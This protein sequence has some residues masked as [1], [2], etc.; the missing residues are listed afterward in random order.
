MLI[1]HAAELLSKSEYAIVLTGAGISTP[2]GIPDFRSSRGGLWSKYDPMLVASLS[3][4]RIW[5][6]KFYQF[7]RPLTRAIFDALPNAAHLALA[8]LEKQGIVKEIIT[9]NVDGLHQKAGS[10]IVHEVHGTVYSLTCVNCYTKYEASSVIEA[11]IEKG[12]IPH[13][14]KCGSILKPDTVLSEEQLPI[15]VWK[16]ADK[17]VKKCDLMLVAGS[18]LEA[19]PVAR[20]PY[21]AINRGAKLI[22]INNEKTYIDPRA[23]VVI[24]KD[25][26]E[27]LPAIVE[28]IKK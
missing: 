22:I 15:R 25:V 10:A 21:D 6:E 3:A 17:A 27:A 11:F 19:F 24:N 18:S 28:K 4:F 13:C 23:D 1:E 20:L 16:S 14:T 5:P 8:D 26:A 12:E 2:S 7:F 9:Q